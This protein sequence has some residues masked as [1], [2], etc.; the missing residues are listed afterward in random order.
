M[1]MALDFTYSSYL[2]ADYR[3]LLPIE[4]GQTV[5]ILGKYPQLAEMLHD[6]GADP[7]EFLDLGS[8]GSATRVDHA[9]IPALTKDMLPKAFLTLS[10]MFTPGGWLLFGTHQFALLSSQKQWEG[11]LKAHRF[12]LCRQYGIYKTLQNPRYLIPL[13]ESGPA[14]HFFH[15]ILVPFS[16][17]SALYRKLAL[18]LVRCNKQSFLFSHR[19]FTAQYRET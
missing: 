13:N 8:V 18:H 10:K 9:I 7:V 6:M 5:L 15:A 17:W 19:V 1:F 16:R 2:H 14:F 3:Y 4:T 11:R 12:Q